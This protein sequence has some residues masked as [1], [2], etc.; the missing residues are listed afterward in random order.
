MHLILLVEDEALIALAEERTLQ[1]FGYQV[2][3]VGTGEAAVEAAGDPNSGIDLVLMDIDLGAGIDGTEAARKILE[4]RR[5]PIVFLTSHAERDCVEKVQGI[6]KYG[7]IIKNSGDFVLKTSIDM[8]FELFQ[9]HDRMLAGEAKLSAL[10]KSIPDLVW[11]KDS[12]GIYLACNKT[13]ERHLGIGE[14][15]IIGKSDY[16]IYGKEEADFYREKDREAIAHGGP[17][18]NE[19]WVT[20]ATDG[21]R[22]LLETI[23]TPMLDDAGRLVGVLGIGRDITERKRTE[24]TLKEREE[25]ARRTLDAI[26]E[27]TNKLEELGLSDFIDLRVLTSLMEDFSALTG[28]GV[29]ILD[30][31][32][33]VLL[34]TGW[35]DICTLFHRVNPESAASCTESDLYLSESVKIGEYVEYRCKNGM[36]DIVTPLFIEDRHVGNIYSGQF[37]YDGDTVDEADFE[38]RA[39]HCG[40]DVDAYLAAL[41]C[42]PHFSRGQISLLMDYLVSLTS[43]VSHLSYSN[44]IL[45]RTTTELKQA[46]EALSDSVREKETLFKELQHR[47]KNSLS[48]VSSLLTLNQ[49][50]V[51]DEDSLRAFREAVDRISCVSMVYEK[52]CESAS[53]DTVDLG[54][55]LGD[56]VEL[57]TAT[58]VAKNSP[59]AVVSRIDSM[60]CDAKRAVSLGLI[61][62]EL[63]TNAM[64]YA[65]RS[66]EPGEIRVSLSVPGDWAELSVSDNGPGFPPGFDASQ[67]PSLGLKIVSLMVENI[68]GNLEYISSRGATAIVRFKNAG[69]PERRSPP[70]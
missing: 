69:G 33:T 8:A 4:K 44:I 5:L 36:W 18:V 16:E 40:F 60:D 47:V 50:S 35:K 51:R 23:K 20:F 38:E 49:A 57:L 11:L 63:F 58:Y 17:S 46:K 61:L 22:V 56:L 19:E 68:D 39:R 59:L 34:A 27:P 62:N 54:R 31:K 65:S 53:S 52:L 43:F 45:A 70:A 2:I 29:A 48:I 9:A 26:V 28:M 30:A 13:F 7:Y 6:T 42:V 21:H 41:R 14:S 1:D 66:G 67:L 15:Q 24:E 10:I 32:G 64:K 3:S 25:S 55:Y 37:F 12:D